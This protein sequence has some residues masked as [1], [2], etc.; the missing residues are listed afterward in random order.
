MQYNSIMNVNICE[1]DD[2]DQA[3]LKGCIRDGTRRTAV[4]S[5]ERCG[6][7]RPSGPHTPLER[8]PINTFVER[9]V[10]CDPTQQM[11]ATLRIVPVADQYDD[12]S[13]VKI[14]VKFNENWST[15]RVLRH[16]L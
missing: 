16:A 12:I 9:R 11:S 10:E 7:H 15:S 8:V 13:T 6:H 3:D 4:Y 1:S 14:F 2:F 5:G